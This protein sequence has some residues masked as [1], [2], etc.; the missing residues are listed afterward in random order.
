MVLPAVPLPAAQR[1][2]L[3][4]LGVV[5]GRF[6]LFAPALLKPRAMALRAQ[7]W[8]VARRE[9]LPALPAPGLVSMAP[10]AWPAGFAEAMGWVAAGP[11]LLRV[12]VAER[13]AAELAFLTRRGPAALPPGLAPRLSIR[14]ESLPAVLR[15][16]GAR[17]VPGVALEPEAFGPLAPPMLAAH[18]GR[19][20][21]RARQPQ[22]SAPPPLDG[23][24]AALAQFRR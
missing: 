2:R 12:D 18:A 16:L 6:A 11:V 13:V 8:A 23:P 19:A 5:A 14:A 15:A 17:L 3:K 7:L 9:A 21:D 22:P 1:A 10:P 24:F 4:P 20:A